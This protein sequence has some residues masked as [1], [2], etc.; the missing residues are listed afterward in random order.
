MK[1]KGLINDPQDIIDEMVLSFATVC[2]RLIKD[3]RPFNDRN[4]QVLNEFINSKKKHESEP[5]SI[6]FTNEYS[7]TKIHT[8]IS[9]PPLV[10]RKTRY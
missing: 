7:W 8:E 9:R 1:D 2:D 6:K 10:H 3:K 4:V 5:F